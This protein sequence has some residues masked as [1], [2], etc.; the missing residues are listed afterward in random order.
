MGSM[1]IFCGFLNMG[2]FLLKLIIYSLGTMLIV[3]SRV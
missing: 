1:L 3:A 2:V